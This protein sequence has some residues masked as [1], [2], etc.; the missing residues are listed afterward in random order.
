M[1]YMDDVFSIDIVPGDSLSLTQD[2]YPPSYVDG[3][4]IV[5]YIVIPEETAITSIPVDD[6][7]NVFIESLSVG[8]SGDWPTG[9]DILPYTGENPPIGAAPG[10][11]IKVSIIATNNIDVASIV[12]LVLPETLPGQKIYLSPNITTPLKINEQ[13]SLGDYDEVWKDEGVNTEGYGS[14]TF[15]AGDLDILW[16]DVPYAFKQ[17][18]PFYDTFGGKDSFG[19]DGYI[20]NLS[21]YIGAMG[22]IDQGMAEQFPEG[23]SR[24]GVYIPDVVYFGVHIQGKTESQSIYVIIAHTT[25]PIGFVSGDVFSGPAKNVKMILAPTEASLLSLE[26][27]N[28]FLGGGAVSVYLSGPAGIGE[29]GD[30]DPIVFSET[31]ASAPDTLYLGNYY[32]N[33][34]I[35][36]D[37]DTF[38]VI[39]EFDT[40]GRVT[41][42]EVDDEHLYYSVF[43]GGKIVKLL[44]SDL[45]FVSEIGTE[46]SG[47][48]NFFRPHGIAVDEMYLYIADR[49][50]HRIVKRLKSDLSFVSKIGTEGSGND[51]FYNPTSIAVD[52]TYLYITDVSNY[53]I[54]KRLK[55]DLSYV[56]QLSI[57]NDD[58]GDSFRPPNNITVDETFVYITDNCLE[59]RV[60]KLLKTNLGYVGQ[61]G[62]VGS[63]DNNL[64][65]PTGI[66]VDE[67]YLY[68][69]DTSNH[70]IIKRLKSDLSYVGQHAMPGS[71]VICLASM[72]PIFF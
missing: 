22:E 3:Y 66:T 72:S 41:G 68:I 39:E 56:A 65:N 6:S 64:L 16:S 12:A 21:I 37:R 55:S 38:L 32:N 59:S 43:L 50:N 30:F 2:S 29:D 63:G 15:D 54:V 62:T 67:T 33:K 7:V 20:E 4:K 13:F 42:I 57:F 1:S 27:H 36:T 48:D 44:Q 9:E 10:T 45:S 40:E 53:R 28:D 69:A 11:V 60:V 35:K 5:S 24:E 71:G 31:P 14:E 17:K 25:L 8:S 23:D 26:Q 70:R 46:G 58:P 49:S 19:E 47:N 34:I 52:E 51:N 18:Y 61:S